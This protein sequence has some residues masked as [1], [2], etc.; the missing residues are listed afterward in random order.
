LVQDILCKLGKTETSSASVHVTTKN[1]ELP[2]TFQ[3]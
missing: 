3:I 1:F 2:G